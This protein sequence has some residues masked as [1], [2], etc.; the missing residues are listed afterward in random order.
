MPTEY[1]QGAIEAFVKLLECKAKVPG[2]VRGGNPPT[3]CEIF[4]NE[5]RAVRTYMNIIH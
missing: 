4:I 5:S 1:R 3:C 2:T